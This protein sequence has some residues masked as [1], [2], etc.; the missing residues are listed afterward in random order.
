MSERMNVSILIRAAQII[1][2]A[3][4]FLLIIVPTSTVYGQDS[5]DDVEEYFGEDDEYEDDEYEDDEYLEDDE[6]DD[7]EYDDE[8]E[9]DEEDESDDEYEDDDENTEF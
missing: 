9:S 5:E 7:E 2:W 6:Y 4:L 1:F 8:D 3:C